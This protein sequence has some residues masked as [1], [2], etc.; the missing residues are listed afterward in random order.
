MFK[1]DG[2]EVSWLIY[3]DWLEDQGLKSQYI[4]DRLNEIQINDWCFEYRN[5]GRVPNGWPEAASYVRPN[6]R[7]VGTDGGTQGVGTPRI[8]TPDP[9]SQEDIF[10]Q[11]MSG[12]GWGCT[13]T[14]TGDGFYV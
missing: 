12:V 7:G 5:T 9:I 8:Y 14:T 6:H 4:R 11:V 10:N 13:Y 3:A 2:S 1:L